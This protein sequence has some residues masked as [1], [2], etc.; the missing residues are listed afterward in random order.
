MKFSAWCQSVSKWKRDDHARLRHSWR[1]KSSMPRKSQRK[2]NH[3]RSKSRVR[4]DE[5]VPHLPAI[6][7]AADKIAARLRLVED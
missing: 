5:L 3:D 7:W 4:Q 1:G 2:K 6:E